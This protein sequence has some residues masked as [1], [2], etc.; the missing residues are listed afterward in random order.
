[1]AKLLVAI[2]VALGLA[3]QAHAGSMKDD[4]A[5]CA[6]ALAPEVTIIHASSSLKKSWLRL[7]TEK[8]YESAKQQIQ[9]SGD[10]D[11]LGLIGANGSFNYD[12]FNEKRRDYLNLDTGQIQDDRAVS[13]FRQT[14]PPQAGEH[15]VQCVSI[16]ATGG[17]GL[18]GWFSDES[19]TYA[20]LHIK[21]RG[22]PSTSVAFKL[23]T[24]GGT[25]TPATA[26]LP[27]DGETQFNIK[28][29]VS[30]PEV[31]V[32]MTSTTPPGLADSVVSVRPS[33]TVG[34]PKP[35]LIPDQ[36]WSLVTA[37]PPNA[38]LYTISN[39]DLNVMAYDMPANPALALRVRGQHVTPPAGD[40]PIAA[41]GQSDYTILAARKLSDFEL[42]PSSEVL[43]LGPTGSR[44][45]LIKT[46]VAAVG[47][48]TYSLKFPSANVMVHQPP[49]I[50]TESTDSYTETLD[51]KR[52]GDYPLASGNVGCPNCGNLF[53]ADLVPKLSRPVARLEAVT[54]IKQT[55]S[56]QWY[57]CYTITPACETNGETTATH[58]R[59]S[60]SCVGRNSCVSWRFS[61]DG[62]EATDTYSLQYRSRQC[63]RYCPQ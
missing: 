5:A 55:G 54:F 33:A 19:A 63:V 42:G 29:S 22:S 37:G 46:P 23:A 4:I 9:S 18:H 44:A 35:T 36:F 58:D 7:I 43:L 45:T 52:S 53:A 13:I 48:K 47:C 39:Q 14:L 15:F 30:A 61:T 12:Q 1:M 8:T 40:Y 6:V 27:H 62:N 59:K 34:P 20:V 25:G 31:R 24:T 57:R 41:S 38:C 2:I 51:Y 16:A 11:L 17:S 28:R 60:G 50:Y 3:A 26:T 32:V 10:V 49:A 56:T 21:F